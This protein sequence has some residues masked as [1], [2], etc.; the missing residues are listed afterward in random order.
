MAQLWPLLFERYGL[1]IAFAHR[2]FAWG[3]DARGKAHVHVVILGLVRFEQTPAV[4]RLFSYEDLNGE[5][6]ESSHA[7]L[8]A[9][10]FD[11]SQMRDP[12][13]VVRESHAPLN[14][15]PPL[16]SGSQPIDGGNYIFDAEERAAF[17]EVEPAAE[18]F[19][20]P[21]VGA[22]EYLNG[23]ER[24][25]LALQNATPANLKGM[26]HVVARMRA[27]R[28]FRSL[29]KRQSTLAIAGY[30]ARYN[31]EV[32]P[33]TAFLVIPE[34]S[35]ER[36]EYIPIGW[37]EPP[38]IPSNK[39]R[40]LPD[41]ERWHFAVLTSTMHVA[42]ARN[43]GGRL[44]SDFQYGIGVVYNTFPIPAFDAAARQL[45]TARAEDVLA[46][47]TG[48]PGATLSDLYD[49]DLM[50]AKL[51]RA[52]AALDQAVDGLYRRKRFTSDRERVE[53]LLALYEAMITPLRLRRQ[54]S[55]RPERRT[56]AGG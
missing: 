30:P 2:T 10:L 17:L 47:R 36:R 34:V 25:I 9:Y 46:A 40:I 27:V 50:P 48:H 11:A 21:Y 35:S 45:L 32:I 41:A 28:D 56:S 19:L 5:P 23:D 33:T 49:P 52:H 6:H 42:W 51:R 44:K 55:A 53:H 3:S 7:A 39:V 38:V 1:E 4:R 15:L 14:A 13:V 12:H 24:W 29:S 26:P 8:S 16:L 54:S 22:H 37:L 20:R 18:R 43:I 31:V